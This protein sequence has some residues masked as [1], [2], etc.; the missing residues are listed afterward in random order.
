MCTLNPPERESE[1]SVADFV[2]E[3]I[4]LLF[5]LLDRYIYTH[6]YLVSSP[7]LGFE[8]T[9]SVREREQGRF[10]GSSKGAVESTLG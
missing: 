1:N 10:R 6:I 4:L 9:V 8:I 5:L 2:L 7:N 3:M